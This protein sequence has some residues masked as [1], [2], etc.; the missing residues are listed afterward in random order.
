LEEREKD[1]ICAALGVDRGYLRVLLYRAR[2]RYRQKAAERVAQQP[3]IP[4]GLAEVIEPGEDEAYHLM[5]KA[6]R[7][8]NCVKLDAVEKAIGLFRRSLDLSPTDPRGHAGLSTCY[9]TAGHFDF[10]PP[11]QAFPLAKTSAD[12][13]LQINPRLAEAQVSI[14]LVSM[15]YDWNWPAAGRSLKK[16]VESSPDWPEG[17][18]YLSWYLCCVREFER[19]IEEATCAIRLDPLSQF[20]HTNLGWVL[21]MASRLDDCIGQLRRTLAYDPCYLPAWALLGCAHLAKGEPDAGLELIAKGAW[22][23]VFVCLG[24]AWAGRHE[25]AR[26]LLEEALA[27]GS[28]HGY[29]PSEIGLIYLA[30]GERSEAEKWLE[31]ARQQRDY[32]IALQMCPEWTP[33]RRDGLVVD[34]LRGMGLPA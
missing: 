19:A 26:R 8:L 1:D 5:L 28:P 25:E 7:F 22:R 20:A 6:R 31:R 27:P 24:N 32:M 23:S 17:H 21:L 16:A 2:S 11:L 34:Y 29:R 33:Y 3:P 14:G 9:T 12:R 13:A 10:M 18:A 4:I 15:F 30:L